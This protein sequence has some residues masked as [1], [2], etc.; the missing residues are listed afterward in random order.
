MAGSRGRT[1]LYRAEGFS[2]FLQ[3]RKID[4]PQCGRK[5]VNLGIKYTQTGTFDVPNTYWICSPWPESL[6]QEVQCRCP[7]VQR[8]PSAAC[9]SI[10]SPKMSAYEKMTINHFFCWHRGLGEGCWNTRGQVDSP[11]GKSCCGA[12]FRTMFVFH[13]NLKTY[14]SWLVLEY[15]RGFMVAQAQLQP[16]SVCLNQ[17]V[18][19]TEPPLERVIAWIS[20]SDGC[21]PGP[22]SRWGL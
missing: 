16:N 18:Q 5:S 17:S 12:L 6:G 2:P 10:S 1:C 4:V 15:Q 9:W 8:S 13:K 20:R 19:D 3:V 14:S 21:P 22:S 7:C 11:L